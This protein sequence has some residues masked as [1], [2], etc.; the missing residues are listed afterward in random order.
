M[1]LLSRSYLGAKILCLAV[2]NIGHVT[3]GVSQEPSTTL[4][5]PAR[6]AQ[7]PIPRVWLMQDLGQFLL[8]FIDS[9]IILNVKLLGWGWGEVVMKAVGKWGLEG[10]KE[11]GRM[12]VWNGC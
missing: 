10:L 6:W 3:P 7:P 12:I 9:E 5:A 11:K 8:I 2:M 1:Y 4:V